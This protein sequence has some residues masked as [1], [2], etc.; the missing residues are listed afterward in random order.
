MTSIIIIKT[1]T[2][3]IWERIPE[4]CKVQVEIQFWSEARAIVRT[5][6]HRVNRHFQGIKKGNKMSLKKFKVRSNIY[7]NKLQEAN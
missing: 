3:S 2:S 5:Y 6:N 1:G 4:V 7:Y